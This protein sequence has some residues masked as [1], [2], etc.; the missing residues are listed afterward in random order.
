VFGGTLPDGSIC[1]GQ[2]CTGGFVAQSGPNQYEEFQR[3]KWTGNLSAQFDSE[4][5]FRGGHFTARLDGS[6]RSKT[7][8]TSDLTIGSGVGL[9]QDAG[10]RKAATVPFT[11]LV[12]G[13]LGLVDLDIGGTKGSI[14]AWGKNIL[15]NKQMTQL[16]GLDL[17]PLGYIGSVIYERARTYGVDVSFS[18]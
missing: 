7:L 3:P 5:I 9:P 6:F 13:R 10:L 8:M 11:W 14:S 4:E 15:N 2:A 1:R 12:N 16:V 17:G 18:F